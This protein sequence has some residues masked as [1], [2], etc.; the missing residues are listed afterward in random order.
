MP[1]RLFAAV[2]RDWCS[3]Q[4]GRDRLFWGSAFTGSLTFSDN[5]QYFDFAR[6]SVF[7][8]VFKYSFIVNQLPLTLRRELFYPNNDIISTWWDDPANRTRTMHRYYYLQ[9]IDVTFFNRVNIGIMEGVM[10][11]NSP[12]ELRYLNPLRVFHSLFSWENYDKWQPPPVYEGWV[13]GDMIGSIFSLEL[14][15]NII[16]NFTFYGQFVMNEY[17]ERG[18]RQRNPNQPPNAL[19]YLAGLQFARPFNAWASIFYLEFIYTDPYLSILSS[20]FGSFIQ[21][22][23]YGQYYYIGYTRDTIALT[24]GANFFKNDLLNISP[25]FSWISTGEHNKHGLIWDWERSSEAFNEST[26]TGIAE[27]KFI[28][29]LGTGWKPH[30]FLILNAS[31]TGIFSANNKH[32][33]GDNAIGG[34]ASFSVSF[35]Y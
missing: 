7:S 27:N 22:N 24:F 1:V 32:I 26:P 11:G 6:F 23:R 15:W 19:G 2:G 30:P 4:I 34:Q 12:L 21:Q 35:R 28:F 13:P 8:Q 3:F 18:E 29:T 31:F 33:S 14:N 20:P 25:T 10:V 5:S 9:R 17:A 16:Q